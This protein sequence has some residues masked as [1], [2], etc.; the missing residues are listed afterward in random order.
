[1]YKE[2]R[3]LGIH[4]IVVLDKKQER[5]KNEMKKNQLIMQRRI[6]SSGMVMRLND[7]KYG[8][9]LSEVDFF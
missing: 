1:M 8:Q 3:Y 5:S 4:F 9:I 6:V 7:T 2:S